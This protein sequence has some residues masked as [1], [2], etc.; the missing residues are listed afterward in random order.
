M[1]DLL[2]SGGHIDAR[3]TIG[4]FARFHDP[5][6]LRYLIPSLDILHLLVLLEIIKFVFI[7]II[8]IV[9]ICLIIVVAVFFSLLDLW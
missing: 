1:F 3:A 2:K 8:V 6:V 7:A 4:V 5:D 9:I